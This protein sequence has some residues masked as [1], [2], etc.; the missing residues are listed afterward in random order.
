MNCTRLYVVLIQ[1]VLLGACRA[2]QADT[3]SS[4]ANATAGTTI[5]PANVESVRKSEQLKAYPVGRYQDPNNPEIM[6]EAHTMYRAETTPQW[7]LNPNAP[8]VV[9]LGPTVAVADVPKQTAALT[10][11]LEQKIQQ[12]TQ[13]L[14]TTYEQNE[15]LSEEIQKLK[16]GQSKVQETVA[17][18]EQ[19]EQELARKNT[20]L[21]KLRQDEAQASAQKDTPGFIQRSW[22]NFWNFLSPKPTTERNAQ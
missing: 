7:N 9:P 21:E 22:D 6:H 18:K 12:Q 11:E 2:P 5:E 8:T 15:R 3:L 13:L 19:L 17:A 16:D 20:E 10:G 4:P 14:Q 1:C